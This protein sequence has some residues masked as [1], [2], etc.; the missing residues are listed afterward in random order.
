MNPGAMQGMGGPPRGAPLNPQQ[1]QQLV[2]RAQAQAQS[3]VYRNRAFEL[4][5]HEQYP[6]GW[7]ST[8]ETAVRAGNVVHL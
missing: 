2:Q 3:Q 1:Q 5:R 4:L 6:S 7:Q 8:I